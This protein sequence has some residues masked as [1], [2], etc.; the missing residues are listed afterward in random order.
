MFKIRC[1]AWRY[2]NQWI[3]QDEDGRVWTQ[4]SVHHC[5]DWVKARS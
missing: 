5:L 1:E 4:G 2:N 3:V